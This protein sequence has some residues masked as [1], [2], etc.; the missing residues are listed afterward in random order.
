MTDLSSLVGI[1]ANQLLGTCKSIESVL[2]QDD[3]LDALRDCSIDDLEDMVISKNVERCDGCDWWFESGDLVDENNE[4]V[5]CED[6]RKERS[7]DHD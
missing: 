3:E 1:L 4:P 6:C 2:D 5:G 7:K